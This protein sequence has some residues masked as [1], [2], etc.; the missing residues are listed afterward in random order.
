MKDIQEFLRQTTKVECLED[1]TYQSL[2]PQIYCK[3]GEHVSIQASRTHY[4][5][6]RIDGSN[7][8]Y[9]IE[10]G[11]PSVIPPLSWKE[12][13]ERWEIPLREKLKNFLRAVR[14]VRFP[15]MRRIYWRQLVNPTPTQT[16]YA[17]MPVEIAQEF[18]DAHGGID[19]GKTIKEEA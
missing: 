6:P 7:N 19:L 16:V 9:D 8:Y 1:Y 5:S 18:I 10:A 17:W 13:A 15:T 12:Y 14:D 2:R 3:D 4:C 11:F